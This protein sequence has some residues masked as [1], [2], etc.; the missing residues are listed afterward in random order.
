MN[1]PILIGTSAVK[2]CGI[3]GVVSNDI[4]LLFPSK[5]A[6]KCMEV[7]LHI[8]EELYNALKP[9]CQPGIY[10]RVEVLIPSPEALL[11]LY[12]ANA[13]RSRSFPSKDKW[14]NGLNVIK[15]LEE[16]LDNNV[17]ECNIS[18]LFDRAEIQ[19][20]YYNQYEK[21]YRACVRYTVK[22]FGDA[23]GMEDRE[24]EDFFKDKVE[25]FVQHD[26]IHLRVGMIY[27][28]VRTE[29]FYEL[30]TDTGKVELDRNKFDKKVV[31]DIDFIWQLFKEELTVLCVERFMLIA[32]HI[33]MTPLTL[34]EI[35]THMKDF[36]IPH[37]I[38]NLCG[39]S[40]KSSE[41]EAY[42]DDGFLRRFLIHNFWTFMQDYDEAGLNMIYDAAMSVCETIDV[43]LA[44]PNSYPL[45]NF[46]EEHIKDAKTLDLL[47]NIPDAEFR[48]TRRLMSDR[49][50]V[51]TQGPNNT[52]IICF[53]SGNYYAVTNDLQVIARGV[54]E[55]SRIKSTIVFETR[56]K[57]E[58]YVTKIY[59]VC[60][61]TVGV[62]TSAGSCG[63][64]DVNL[65]RYKY[66]QIYI[67]RPAVTVV[68]DIS[69][70]P[71]FEGLIRYLS[72][73]I[74][75]S[76]LGNDTDIEAKLTVLNDEVNYV[77]PIDQVRNEVNKYIH[78]TTVYRGDAYLVREYL[79]WELVR[80]VKK[81]VQRLFRRTN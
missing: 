57:K 12:R 23:P 4:D 46:C 70:A 11:M 32:R 31:E 38:T 22:N 6:P 53:F 7:D 74:D 5:K 63:Y 58:S 42:S 73:L 2:A 76:A 59:E 40:I 18:Y 28:R 68:G 8:S 37:F 35:C 9:F 71:Y 54:L 10:K 44:K 41:P 48:A 33:G 49:E 78:D 34:E 69:K 52:Q 27:R 24:N 72:T 1:L 79:L 65:D 47:N 67:S 43:P 80:D 21:L 66:K 81:F 14:I 77:G 19:Y 45:K 29:L 36:L 64:L 20:G 51:I 50:L 25:R 55:I 39:S 62:Y 26:E 56:E 13:I 17:D 15:I 61:A 16:Y 75:F 30:K 3:K 60:N